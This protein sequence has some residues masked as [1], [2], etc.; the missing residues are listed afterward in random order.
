ME[1]QCPVAAHHRERHRE[2]AW[3]GPRLP[4]LLAYG[5]LSIVET[6]LWPRRRLGH[7]PTPLLPKCQEHKKEAT[8]PVGTTC[9]TWLK[10][11]SLH[12]WFHTLQCAPETPV[13][14]LSSVSTAQDRSGGGGGGSEPQPRLEGNDPDR[15]EM[16]PQLQGPKALRRHEEDVAL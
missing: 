1:L 8:L 10:A 11:T 4:H 5:Q 9:P 14:S 12:T 7:T 15:R 2:S 3:P 13:P 16:Y 6:V